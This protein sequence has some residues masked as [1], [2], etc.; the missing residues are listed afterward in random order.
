MRKISQKALS[1]FAREQALRR[2]QWATAEE[3]FKAA[4]HAS[5][6]RWNA[7]RRW[8]EEHP[9]E[10]AAAAAIAKALRELAPKHNLEDDRLIARLEQRLARVRAAAPWSVNF[11]R[12]ARRRATQSDR[13]T[14]RSPR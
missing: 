8:R 6:A 5:L 12:K 11:K 1:R 4:Q 3:R 2:W 14:S 9:Q 13:I 7:F 10:A